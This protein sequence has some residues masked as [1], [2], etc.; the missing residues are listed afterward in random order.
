MGTDMGGL[1][2]LMGSLVGGLLLGLGMSL[3]F[4]STG[5]DEGEAEVGGVGDSP[6][7][8]ATR[9]IAVVKPIDH[10][11]NVRIGPG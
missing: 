9:Q 7:V 3:L 6:E 1:G 11:Q 8:Q 5:L 2:N 10:R 4:V